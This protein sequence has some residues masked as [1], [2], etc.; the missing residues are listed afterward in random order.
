MGINIERRG[1]EK[2]S[3]LALEGKEEKLKELGLYYGIVIPL[4][5]VAS[6]A[7]DAKPT[8]SESEHI[9]EADNEKMPF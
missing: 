3:T 1:H 7:Q 5:E 9:K 8:Q 2:V 4:G 6:V